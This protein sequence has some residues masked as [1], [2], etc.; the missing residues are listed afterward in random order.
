VLDTAPARVEGEAYQAPRHGVSIEAL[1]ARWEAA[2][3]QPV[4]SR[5]VWAVEAGRRD[6]GN[7]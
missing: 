5:F 7:A 6:G 3:G 4:A 2:A 1:A